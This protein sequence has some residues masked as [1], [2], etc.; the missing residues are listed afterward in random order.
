MSDPKKRH[1]AQSA[2]GRSNRQ[3]SGLFVLF[4]V[5]SMSVI[6]FVAGTR[7]DEIVGVMKSQMNIATAGETLDLKEVQQTYRVLKSKYNGELDE[8]KLAQFAS[9]GMI[10]AA[11]DPYTEYYTAKEAQKVQDELSGSIGGGIGAEL[12]LR[13]G[14]VTVIRPL[15]DS[16]AEAAGVQAG[17]VFVAVNDKIVQDKTVEDVVQVVRGEVGSTVKLLL[18]RGAERKEISVKRAAI[19]AP[20]VESEKRGDVGVITLSRFGTDSAIKMR[21]A[22]EEL[23]K[24]GVKGIVLDLRGNGGG[25]LQAGVD[26]AGIWLNDKVVVK[27][28]GSNERD[29]EERTGND[30]LLEGMPTVVLIN[31]G[32]ASASEIVAGALSYHKAATIMGEKSY[33]KGSVQE[34]VDLA[35]GDM[36]KVTIANWYTPSDKSISKEGI[37]PDKEV[38]LTSDDVN[39][40]RD[41]QLDAAMRKLAK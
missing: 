30:A 20:D 23:K 18:E 7:S 33:G 12:G 6:G 17:D 28:K 9:K 27:E 10:E 11:G 21:A 19:V 31:A 34:L 41:P 13:N 22:A 29:R 39:A 25:Y 32:S 5:I 26:V 8:S 24:Q 37:K 16:P 4:A 14:R 2:S 35:N 38:K 15:K 1:G 36:L 40:D 3:F